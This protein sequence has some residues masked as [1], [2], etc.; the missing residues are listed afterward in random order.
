MLL[1][2]DPQQSEAH[3]RD[4]S[5]RQNRYNERE[6]PTSLYTHNRTALL[7]VPNVRRE[8]GWTPASSPHPPAKLMHAPSGEETWGRRRRYII[9]DVAGY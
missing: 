1:V 8:I 2:L 5:R 7:G 4:K 3:N 9:K 6:I